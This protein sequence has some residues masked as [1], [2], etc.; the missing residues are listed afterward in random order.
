MAMTLDGIYYLGADLN[1]AGITNFRGIGTDIL[2]FNGVL[3]GRGRAIRNLHIDS[4]VSP[5]HPDWAGGFVWGIFRSVGY[6]G[7]I[8]N[9]TVENSSVRGIGTVGGLVGRNNGII[10]DCLI[11]VSVTNYYWRLPGGTVAGT[12]G[13][14][15]II[16]N[17]ISL[18]SNSGP[19]VV[20]AFA[21]LNWGL[22]EFSLVS[23]AGLTGVYAPN[24]FSRP[25]F[26]TGAPYW[27]EVP[28][29][30]GSPM[31]D[32]TTDIVLRNFAFQPIGSF[33]RQV[34]FSFDRSIWNITQGELPRLIV[35]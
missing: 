9:L 24:Y 4:G 13:E 33:I 2:E 22:I 34:Y 15:G 12:N 27:A 14:D 20:A 26:N 35:Q 29:T 16:E 7:E 6:Y 17:V 1:F 28:V 32:I 19:G 21:G 18:G 31:S 5:E 3:D 23:N 25:I 11:S 10:W 8:F 30:G